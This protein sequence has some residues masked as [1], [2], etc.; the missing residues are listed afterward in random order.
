MKQPSSGK[1]KLIWKFLK[2]DATAQQDFGNPAV[3]TDYA[4]CIYAGTSNTLINELNVALHRPM[5]IAPGT[6]IDTNTGN[7]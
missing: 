3:N 2:G 1:D 5:P 6:S 7:E 4:I